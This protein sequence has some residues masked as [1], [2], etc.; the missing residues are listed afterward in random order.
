[1][2]AL[3]FSRLAQ[4]FPL[5]VS[6]AGTGFCGIYLILLIVRYKRESRAEEERLS[7]LKPLSYI[8]WIVG[9]IGL[10][11]IAGMLIA[12][13]V[14]LFAFLLLESNMTWIRSAVSVVCVLVLISAA[15]ALLGVYWPTN[16]LGI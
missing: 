3:E 13:T 16:L 5:Y 4:F 12:T 7:F 15:S 11:Y 9:Y 14:F 10:I 1:M 6:V 8:G 2:S